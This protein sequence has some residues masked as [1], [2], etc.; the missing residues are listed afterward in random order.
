MY[1][2]PIIS[3]TSKHLIEWSVCKPLSFV[4]FYCYLLFF[5]SFQR[6]DKTDTLTQTHRSNRHKTKEKSFVARKIHNETQ[7][8]TLF[9]CFVEISLCGACKMNRSTALLVRCTFAH[10]FKSGTA[11]GKLFQPRHHSISRVQ[12]RTGKHELQPIR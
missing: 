6:I 3:D 9:S 4:V 7:L 2:A 5:I 8:L 10:L 11:T 12:L 1:K